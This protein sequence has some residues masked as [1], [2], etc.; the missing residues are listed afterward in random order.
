MGPLVRPKREKHI[1][2]FEHGPILSLLPAD[3]NG[4]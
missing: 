3:L 4:Y 1:L 2:W